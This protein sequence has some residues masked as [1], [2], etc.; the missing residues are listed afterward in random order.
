[1][2]LSL[3][4]KLVAP[5]GKGGKRWVETSF[6]KLPPGY[7]HPHFSPWYYGA[8][9]F[10]VFL[11]NYV[12][13]S[14]NTTEDSWHKRLYNKWMKASEFDME[15]ATERAIEHEKK[16]EEQKANPNFVQKTTKAFIKFYR[17]M[18]TSGYVPE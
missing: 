17:K 18:T 4:L 2:R 12:M 14:W 15:A 13:I 6:K 10:C 16:L 9:T 1:M 7:P 3:I 5:D 8:I 11:G